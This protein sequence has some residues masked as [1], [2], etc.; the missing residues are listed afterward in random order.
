MNQRFLLPQR[1]RCE[2]FELKHGDQ[3]AV[4]MITV[5]FYEDGRI[6]EVF[7][8]GAKSGSGMEGVTHDGAILLSLALQYGVPLDTI[9]HAI[10]RNLDGSAATIIGAVID[11][12]E[13][14]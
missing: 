5:G 6:G 7:I 11:R 12:I 9:R 8:N 2:T 3:N 13:E 1:R 14:S 4:Y 10:G